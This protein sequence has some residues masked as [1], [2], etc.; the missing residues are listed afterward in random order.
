MYLIILLYFFYFADGYTHLKGRKFERK[1]KKTHT[2]T[3]SPHTHTTHKKK[4]NLKAHLYTG[5]HQH[6]EAKEN[7]HHLPSLFPL[8]VHN[9]LTPASFSRPK[10]KPMHR[11]LPFF[12]LTSN[13]FPLHATHLLPSADQQAFFFLLNHRHTITH[14]SQTHKKIQVVLPSP[15]DNLSSLSLS[16]PTTITTSSPPLTTATSLSFPLPHRWLPHI[17][18]PSSTSLGHN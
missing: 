8:T 16:L 6:Q 14:H 7:Q 17:F 18:H 5:S 4:K 13:P 11:G 9:H 3:Y 10:R 15:R 1:Q 12:L 2:H